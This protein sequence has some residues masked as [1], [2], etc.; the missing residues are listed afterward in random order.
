VASASTLTA[1]ENAAVKALGA[2][3]VA[4]FDFGHDEYFIA[5]NQAET[6]VSSHDAVVCL[7][8]V[9]GFTSSDPFSATMSNG[10]VTLH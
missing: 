5:T 4:Y 7:V 3:G 2:A 8:G 10:I 9:S 6:S 1:A